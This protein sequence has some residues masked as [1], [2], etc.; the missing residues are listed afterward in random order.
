MPTGLR[1]TTGSACPGSVGRAAYAD[2]AAVAEKTCATK[3]ASP[4]TR[5]IGG[6]TELT[7]ADQRYCFAIREC[8]DDVEAAPLLCAG[9]IGYRTLRL[10]G[11][12]K[13]IGIYG[14]GAAAHIVA[15]VARHQ[16]RQVFA[17]TRPGDLAA[18][19]FVRSLGAIWA[20]GSDETRP[21]R[22]MPP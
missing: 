20:G 18:Q 17:F 10:A 12:G 15:Q 11:P 19:D 6:Y 21:I 2:T 5:S 22:S 9:L 4:A 16:A 14:F 8:F 1:S 13:R 7:V 3:P